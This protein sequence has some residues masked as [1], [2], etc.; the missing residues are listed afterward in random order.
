MVASLSNPAAPNPSKLM[1]QLRMMPDQQLVQYAQMHKNDPYIFPMAFQESNTRKQMRAAQY[2]QAAQAPKVVDQDLQEMAAQTPQVAQ[3]LPEEQGI[4]TLSA[5][6]MQNMAGGGIV[7][8]EDGGQVPG[9]AKGKYVKP[10][11][12]PDLYNYIVEQAKLNNVDPKIALA[13]ADAERGTDVN[14]A[15]KRSTAK[16]IFQITDQPYKG[17]GGDPAKRDDPYENIRVGTKLLGQNAQILRNL[18]KREPTPG[19]LYA[20]HFLGSTTGSKLLFTD[21]NTPVKDFLR[22]NNSEKMTEKILASNPEVLGGNKTVGDVRNWADKTVTKFLPVVPVA[23]AVAAPEV[24]KS[25]PAPAPVNPAIDQIPGQSVKAPPA[26]NAGITALSREDVINQIPGQTVKAPAA[27]PE[28]TGILSPGWFE[29]KAENM[30]LSKDVGRN[31]F[32]TLM[33]PTPAAP[34]TTLP[35]AS[36]SGLGLAALGERIY[37]KIVPP[38]GMSQKEIAALR[39]ETEAAKAAEIAQAAQLPQRLTPPA[40]VLEQGAEVIPVTQAGEATV[41]SA[42]DLEKARLANQAADQLAASQRAAQLTQEA[43][44]LPSLAER[45]QQA[46][47]LRESDEAARLMARARAATS[48]K[49]AAQTSEGLAAIAPTTEELTA[50]NTTA[51]K[52]PPGIMGGATLPTVEEGIV[53][54][55][56]DKTEEPANIPTDEKTGGTDWNRLMLQMGLHLMAGKS[57]NALTNVGEAGLG[58]LAMQQAEAKALSDIETKK[59][60]A[61]YRKKM[62]EYY[63]ESAASIARGAKEKNLQLEAEKLIA[64]EISKDKFLN[65]PGQEAARDARERQMRATI[66][67]QLGIEPTM[68]AGAP[69]S[70]GGFKIL[71]SRPS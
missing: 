60:E 34:I 41:Q 3:A 57:P 45:L 70:L 32:N 46:S 19:E 27:K 21:P 64:Q 35:K 44:K 10:E 59:S 67:R 61:E 69:D 52:Y 55:L 4:G 18:N 42:A 65:M 22:S 7:A 30:G 43:S 36:S 29:Q 17:A 8:F 66:Y 5:P 48:A 31:V 25:A 39:A 23:T 13:I 9:Y 33:A 20:T 2:P 6:N 68:A 37:N 26:K 24:K 71:G 53:S 28:E 63:G 12:P 56:K 38:A 40:Q 50:D 1:A 49:T 58:T 51:N 47:Y 16:G 54:A 15:N 14:E 62:G 11:L